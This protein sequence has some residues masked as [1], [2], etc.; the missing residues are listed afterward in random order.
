MINDIIITKEEARFKPEKIAVTRVTVRPKQD[1]QIFALYI[2]NTSIS[3][4]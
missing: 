1:Y 2:E 4:S 3:F